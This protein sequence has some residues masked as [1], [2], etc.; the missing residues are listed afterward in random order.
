MAT[1]R[2]IRTLIKAKKVGGM[3]M[4]IPLAAELFRRQNNDPDVAPQCAASFA[5]LPAASLPAANRNSPS[6][7]SR[8][9]FEEI[10]D[11]N[12][13][14]AEV[15]TQQESQ[16]VATPRSHQGLEHTLSHVDL[17]EHLPNAPSHAVAL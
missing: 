17:E 3:E 7:I 15:M 5:S 14:E 9:E 4:Y 8:P 2:L 16:Q 11:E 13:A 1:P 6:N 10:M 12:E